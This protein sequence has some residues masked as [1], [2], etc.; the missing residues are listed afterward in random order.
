MAS[1]FQNRSPSAL[2]AGAALG[3]A[4]CSRG[5]CAPAPGSR[6]GSRAA[7][8]GSARRRIRARQGR[9]SRCLLTGLGPRGTGLH[10]PG[11]RGPWGSNAGTKRPSALEAGGPGWGA[12]DPPPR[13]GQGSIC[14]CPGDGAPGG[15]STW[16]LP[17]VLCV[18]SC[19]LGRT[20]VLLGESPPPPVC[21]P[22]TQDARRDPVSVSCRVPRSRGLRIGHVD[23]AGDTARPLRRV[24]AHRPV[25]RCSRARG[26]SSATAAGG[27]GRRP[28]ET[29]PER[30]RNRGL[31]RKG[32]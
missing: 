5:R 25:G 12:G 4:T 26:F 24:R 13:R 27:R 21:P 30:A 2:S 17:A 9:T 23:V 8:E 19:R 6:R 32:W 11:P 29:G 28:P 18:R 22:L 15:T 14:L 1:C 7:F 10:S 20:P 16:R 31:G 3:G